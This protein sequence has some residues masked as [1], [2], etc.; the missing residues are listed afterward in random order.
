MKFYIGSNPND[1]KTIDNLISFCTSDGINYH[2][3]ENSAELYTWFEKSLPDYTFIYGYRSSI[4]IKKFSPLQL[5]VFNIHPGK[6]PEFRGPQP[7]FWQLK[8][9]VEKLGL[10]IHLLTEQVD[11]GPIVWSREIPN[12]THLSHG[13]ADFL[14]SN[15]L[16]EG[17]NY[18]I[19]SHS[20]EVLI[21]AAIPQDDSLAHFY[22]RPVL[23]DV[24]INW[25]RMTAAEI[26]NLVK[27][28]NPW[29]IGPI[30]IFQNIEVKIV[31]AEPGLSCVDARLAGTIIDTRSGIRVKSCDDKSVVINHL[32]INGI[33]V[34][35]RYAEKFGF[36]D[37]QQ[38]ISP[39]INS[40][41]I[42]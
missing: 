30:S 20:P 2:R 9:G 8:N 13:L 22:K 36:A 25:N 18:I 37:G 6:L 40:S 31:D 17:I 1:K 42:I 16:I 15:L 24:L 27:A 29:N 10:S 7:V 5:K 11:S 33:F 39:D 38:F 26:I 32:Q 12:E 14:F 28:C 35:W 19:S 3:E 23:K 34:P 21:K 41:D 4:N